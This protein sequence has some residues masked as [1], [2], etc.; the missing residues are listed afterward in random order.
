MRRQI[1][2]PTPVPG[3]LLGRM[4]ALEGREDD[5][6][7]FRVEADP[8]VPYRDHPFSPF[9][10]GADVHFWRLVRLPIFQG[11]TN[12]VLKQPDHLAPIYRQGR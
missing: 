3:Y 4:Q 11:I 8:V 6:R 9:L 2:R 10:F 7:K 1:A 12:Q 5:R